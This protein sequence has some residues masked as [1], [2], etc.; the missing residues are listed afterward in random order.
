MNTYQMQNENYLN[1]QKLTSNFN[2]ECIESVNNF[3]SVINKERQKSD[4][5]NFNHKELYDEKKDKIIIEKDQNFLNPNYQKDSDKFI[6]YLNDFNN[7]CI[8]E[9]EDLKEKNYQENNNKDL[10]TESFDNGKS[11]AIL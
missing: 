7:L 1:D 3:F 4:I 8:N 5:N 11:F 6:D 10:I 9:D 2:E